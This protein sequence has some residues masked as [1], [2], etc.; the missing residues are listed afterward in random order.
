VKILYQ[1]FT[2]SSIRE[3]FP[4]EKSWSHRPTNFVFYLCRLSI[5]LLPWKKFE[6]RTKQVY[7]FSDPTDV[8]S[9]E[10]DG[11]SSTDSTQPAIININTATKEQ[12]ETLPG[13]G[14]VLAQRIL[15]YIQENGPFET[16]SQLTL[17]NGIGVKILEGILDFATVGG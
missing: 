12:L 11:T 7:N 8:Q 6:R 14:P 9:S 4:F 1:Q 15:D 16:M 3:V 5:R 17:V 13:I 10:S 2:N